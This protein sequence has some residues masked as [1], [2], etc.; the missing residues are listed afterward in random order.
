MSNG[1]GGSNPPTRQ[2]GSVFKRLTLAI[3][4]VA[5]RPVRVAG[6]VVSAEPDGLTRIIIYTHGGVN[7]GH[8]RNPRPLT[9]GSIESQLRLYLG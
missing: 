2:V 8:D 6:C 1:S 4:W 7:L 3:R 5:G 9:W